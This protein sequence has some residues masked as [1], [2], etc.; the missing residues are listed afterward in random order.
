MS[1]DE[2]VHY[3]LTT[4]LAGLESGAAF[5]VVEFGADGVTV[6]T[7]FRDGLGTPAPRH[8]ILAD[9]PAAD[10]VDFF[11]DRLRPLLD[12]RLLLV[13]T[14]TASYPRDVVQLLRY[15][16][17]VPIYDCMTP[18]K[19]HIRAVIT[20]SPLRTF[21]ELLV[22]RQGTD[23]QLL[24]DLHSLFPPDATSGYQANFTIRCAPTDEQGTVFAVV[25]RLPA[26][27]GVPTAPARP[28]PIELQSAVV[29]PGTYN[30]RAELVRPGHVDFQGLPV[31]L[32]P[33]R[34]RLQEIVRR[35]PRQLK[36]SE[37]AHLVCMLEVS[38]GPEPLEHRIERLE[39]LISTAE[40]GG[41]PLRVSVVTYG[42]HAV[43]RN[44]A[45]A[46]ASALAWATTSTL[47]V[48]TLRE[49]KGRRAPEREYS[50]AAQVE[51]A[52]REVT[53]RLTVRDGDPVLVTVGSRPPHPPKVDMVTEIIPCREK[54]RWQDELNR[55]RATLPEL[56]FGALSG[57]GAVGEI[58]RELGRDAYA[59]VDVVDMPTFA[60]QLGLHGPVQAVPFPIMGQRGT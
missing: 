54:V 30:V 41:R 47:A 53:S 32:E 55:L 46:P 37:A 6:W 1:G 33:V 48:R 45:E 59:E 50:R 11:N 49:V 34:Q 26:V 22:L 9:G 39:S 17:N 20:A 40:Q 31:K 60:A 3:A 58:W 38:G 57:E 35:V 56:R 5:K 19:D 4:E 7:I 12:G 51:C 10:P 14:T 15:E 36:T 21:Y 2:S 27:D 52:L 44:V 24:L 28:H 8:M 43:E 23:G 25:T 29:T 16:S 42:P 13:A 18:L